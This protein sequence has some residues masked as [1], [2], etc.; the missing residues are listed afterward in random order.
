MFTGTVSDFDSDGLFGVISADDGRLLLFNLRGTPPP[1]HE[2]F[3]IGTRVQFVE[4]ESNPA[5]RA[6]TLVPI[7]VEDGL[8]GTAR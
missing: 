7:G 4:R 2:L 1:L 3:R 6:I 5:S 8:A